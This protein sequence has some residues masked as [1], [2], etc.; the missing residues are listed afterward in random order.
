MIVRGQQLQHGDAVLDG[1]IGRASFIES[2]PAGGVAQVTV[3]QQI[4]AAEVVEQGPVNI[5]DQQL[6]AVIQQGA[7]DQVQQV[8]VDAVLF[9]VG[10]DDDGV[11]LI[12]VL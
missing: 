10:V 11:I 1:G 6:D 7:P 8:G 4:G 12:D 5:A 3:W 9:S 2:L